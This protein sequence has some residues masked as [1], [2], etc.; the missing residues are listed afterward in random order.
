MELEKLRNASSVIPCRRSKVEKQAPPEPFLR[1]QR[2]QVA[3]SPLVAAGESPLHPTPSLGPSSTSVPQSIEKQIS[4]GKASMIRNRR[5]MLH[6]LEFFVIRLSNSNEILISHVV[7]TKGAS[8]Y[9]SAK[10]E[11]PRLR[12]F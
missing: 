11:S 12:H 2:L 10:L 4:M 6:F 3:A 7:F 5:K 1:I 8:Q 9:T